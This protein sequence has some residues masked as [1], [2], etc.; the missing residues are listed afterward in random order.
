MGNG[1]GKLSR[2]DGYGVV[3]LFSN[4]QHIVRTYDGRQSY[5]WSAEQGDQHMR[6]TYKHT[7]PSR[8]L[9]AV[10]FKPAA[11]NWGQSHTTRERTTL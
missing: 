8:I 1:A 2:Y 7:I 3:L 11:A 4:F 10:T 9:I 5:V 6:H